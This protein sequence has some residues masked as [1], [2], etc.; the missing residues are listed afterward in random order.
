LLCRV[1]HCVCVACADVLVC[2]EGYKEVEL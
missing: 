2:A 1:A